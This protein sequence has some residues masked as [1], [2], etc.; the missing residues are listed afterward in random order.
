MIIYSFSDLMKRVFLFICTIICLVSLPVSVENIETWQCK[1]IADTY[2]MGF[3]KQKVT[4]NRVLECLR[5]C[6][7]PA[8]PKPGRRSKD[9][10]EG[11]ELWLVGG[12]EHEVLAHPR[13]M[14]EALEDIGGRLARLPR[15]WI[16]EYVP[17]E[18]ARRWIEAGHAFADATG[19]AHIVLPGLVVRVLGNKPPLLPRKPAQAHPARAWRGAALRV[20]FHL[21]CDP[22]LTGRTVR[23]LAELTGTAPGTIVNVL[24]DLEQSGQLVRLGARK[25]RFVPD[26]DLRERWIGEYGRKL[27]PTLLT[28]RFTAD[29]PLWQS[30]FDPT[31]YGAVWGAEAAAALLGADLRPAVWTLYTAAPPVKLLAAARLRADPAG[32]VELRG[33]FWAEALATPRPDTTPLLL[34]VADLLATRDGRCHAAAVDLRSRYI[35]GPVQ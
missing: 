1:C 6:G 31:L 11:A 30:D 8:R 9:L 19:N 7:V 15:L 35:D 33:V 21:L 24:D 29:N 2:Q 22:A 3:E 23:E 28:G 20:M 27:R 10:P 5:G 17:D 26:R 4:K 14:D 18:T 32:R 12:G 16:E 13:S 34:I 25:R